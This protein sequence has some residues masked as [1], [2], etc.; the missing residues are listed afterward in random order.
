MMGQKYNDREVAY[1]EKAQKNQTIYT[2][3]PGLW[4]FPYSGF[5]IK[6]AEWETFCLT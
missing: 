5:E 2:S 1:P 3:A 6:V 4:I